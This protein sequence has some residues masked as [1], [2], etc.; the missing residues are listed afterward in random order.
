V[1]VDTIKLFKFRNLLD[2]QVQ[3]APGV[4]I[5]VGRNGQGKTNLLEAV[6]FLGLSKSFRTS[7]SDELVQWGAEAGAV[8]GRLV[9]QDGAVELGISLESGA[10]RAYINKEP[11]KSLG[12]Y[13]GRLVTVTFAPRDVFLVKGG[14]PERRNL[15]DRALVD[16][17][18]AYFQKL[19]NYQRAL[20][21]RNKMLKDQVGAAAQYEPWEAL[22]ATEAAEITEQRRW[23][24]ETLQTRADR[25]YWHFSTEEGRLGLSLRV[26][27][28]PKEL[29]GRE[30]YLEQYRRGRQQE[31]RYR[32]TLIGPHL[33][34]IS[35]ELGGHDSKAFASQGQTRSIVLSLT[36]G[37]IELLEEQHNDSPVILLDDVDSELDQ[38]RAAAFFQ[39]IFAQ[40]RQ[41]IMTGTNLEKTGAAATPNESAAYRIEA[42]RIAPLS[43]C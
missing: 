17:K 28:F 20:R 12:Q 32:S 2:Q 23:F 37:I 43:L 35:I 22:L 24:I 1:F 26:K 36:L 34:D 6:V 19:L 41:V 8:F 33:D 11:V 21:H 4:N 3:F 31:L 18:P 30:Q 7:R 42:G 16:L 25:A 15:I 40:R 14:P 10:K 29:P 9:R 27:G 5:I 38:Y 39:M 13:L